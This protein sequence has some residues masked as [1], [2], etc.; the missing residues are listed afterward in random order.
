M[1]KLTALSTLIL[2]AALAVPA[3]AADYPTGSPREARFQELAKRWQNKATAPT[4]AAKSHCAKTPVIG[5]DKTESMKVRWE[6]LTDAQRQAIKA[7]QVA[8]QKEWQAMT[9]E[10]R[11]AA[12]IRVAAA[13]DTWE[14]M[15]PAEREA[16]K[17]RTLKAIEATR[18]KAKNK[19]KQ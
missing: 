9:P 15:T 14:S 12:Q 6:S 3:V 17:K 4:L 13:R 10:Q 16:A 1:K 5:A 2:L 7:R 19:Q 8:A 11:K 18:E